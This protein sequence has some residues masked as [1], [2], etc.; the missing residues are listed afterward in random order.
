VNVFD[1]KRGAF[2][3]AA[4]ASHSGTGPYHPH[5]EHVAHVPHD[6]QVLG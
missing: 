2:I 1:V 3:P 6:G 5:V 4:E